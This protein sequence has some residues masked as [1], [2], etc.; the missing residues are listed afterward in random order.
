M[1]LINDII[2]QLNAGLTGVIHFDAKFGLSVLRPNQKESQWMYYG[3][4]GELVPINY[5]AYSS[6]LF[7]T[8][9]GG[10]TIGPASTNINL[11]PCRNMVN[12]SVPLRLIYVGRRD[13]FK[14]D[15]LGA[16]DTI[17]MQIAA[18]LYDYE[19]VLPNN[20]KNSE[21]IAAGY[22]RE[23]TINLPFEYVSGR[24]NFNLTLQTFT[25]CIGQICEQP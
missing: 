9:N 21:I 20:F 7:W 11:N 15:S 4:S 8:R 19:L 6:V 25:D 18:T 10:V 2:N 5:D 17:G 1:S 13:Q 12:V 3:G 16:E 24:V 23:A 22:D 14:C